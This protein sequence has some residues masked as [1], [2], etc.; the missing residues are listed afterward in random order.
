MRN[1]NKDNLSK[2]ELSRP[3]FIDF[4]GTTMEVDHTVNVIEI[5]LVIMS[6]LGDIEER[7]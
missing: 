1:R 2:F 4:M 5:I 6:Y 7:N 3:R